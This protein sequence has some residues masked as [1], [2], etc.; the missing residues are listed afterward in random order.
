MNFSLHEEAIHLP[1]HVPG[2]CT[3]RRWR[4]ESIS[5]SDRDVIYSDRNPGQILSSC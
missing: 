3:T 1:S 5:D 4:D 2:N